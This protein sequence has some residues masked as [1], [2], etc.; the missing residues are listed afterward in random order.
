[1][2]LEAIQ[3]MDRGCDSYGGV[4]YDSTM[5]VDW[6]ARTVLDGEF[7]EIMIYACWAHSGLS[8]VTRSSPF[9]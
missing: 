9:L 5:P 1:V 3:S 4:R 7:W 6:E 2:R 8:T